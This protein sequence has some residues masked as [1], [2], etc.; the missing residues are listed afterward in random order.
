M[1]GRTAGGLA[2]EGVGWAGGDLSSSTGNTS[3]FHGVRYELWYRCS[4]IVLWLIRRGEGPAMKTGIR[5]SRLLPSGHRKRAPAARALPC[6]SPPA[7]LPLCSYSGRYLHPHL[8]QASRNCT[9]CEDRDKLK[10]FTNA[11][12]LR[13]AS[14]ISESTWG[15]RRVSVRE[16][17]GEERCSSFDSSN[18]K[19]FV[20][21]LGRWCCAS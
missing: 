6:A 14:P 16:R 8:P 17:K 19:R 1:T 13:A 9:T 12:I 4:K 3:F 7:A 2:E 11:N 15:W 18:R 21:L 5:V 20:S 10:Q